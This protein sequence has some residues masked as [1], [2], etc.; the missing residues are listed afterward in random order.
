MKISTKVM[1]AFKSG[2]GA[3]SLRD[4]LRWFLDCQQQRKQPQQNER[5]ATASLMKAW[6]NQFQI[7]L[8]FGF[9][10]FAPGPWQLPQP[11]L[12]LFVDQE[13]INWSA[14]L[15]MAYALQLRQALP[16]PYLVKSQYDQLYV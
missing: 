8:G 6:N 15:F 5:T 3:S 13:S 4:D 12:T 14:G 10:V 9:D 2:A 1:R 7:G 11:S 16:L